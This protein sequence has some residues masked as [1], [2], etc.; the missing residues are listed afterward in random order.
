MATKRR[1][2]SPG[3]PNEPDSKPAFPYAELL[4]DIRGE[5]NKAEAAIK[6][7]E[8]VALEVAFP[9]IIELRYAGRRIV[10]AL[11]AA[12]RGAGEDKVRAFL[13]DARFCCHRSQH[14]AIDA[15]MSKIGID[16]DDLTSRL[17]FDAVIAAYP[18]F[19]DFYA[20]FTVA[21]EKIVASRENREDRIGIYD[22]IMAVDLPN[23]I[24]RYERIMAVRPIAKHAALR[25]RLGG[26]NGAVVLVVAI[27]AMTFAG[28]AVDWPKVA[29]WVGLAP[30]TK[31]QSTPPPVPKVP[32]PTPRT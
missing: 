11:D 24:A 31:T 30:A 29:G 7:S 5:W 6:R 18:E 4:R 8:Q 12:H 2:G 17:G 21:R 13:E 27:L 19:R 1:Q 23:M 14:D 10:D 3:G 15:A 32:T 16:L 26:I 28:L 20:D 9:S 25:R 22:A